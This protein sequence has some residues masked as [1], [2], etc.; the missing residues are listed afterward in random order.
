M[1]LILEAL[2]KSE[3]ERQAASLPGLLTPS[4]AAA[5]MQRR[6]P[7]WLWWLPGMLA[8]GLLLGWWLPHWLK[9]APPAEPQAEDRPKEPAATPVVVE[10]A[11]APSPPEQTA[12]PA[13]TE[14]PDTPPAALREPARPTA[15]P[16]MAIP[17]DTAAP[18]EIAIP[19]PHAA[20]PPLAAPVA[21]EPSVPATPEPAAPRLA[22][23]AQMPSAQRQRL[24]ELKLSVHVFNDDPAARFAIVDGRRLQ[25]GDAVGTG[26]TLRE[27]RREG[28]LLE[29]DGGSWLLERPR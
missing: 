9:D 29:I 11:P 16:P 28:L 22:R 20:A 13:T 27:I 17:A 25:E 8:A 24:P 4:P 19:A 5:R 15:A 6:H 7:A 3:A 21:P 26:V 10:A 1:S 18:V 2:R 12:G 14:R 23:L